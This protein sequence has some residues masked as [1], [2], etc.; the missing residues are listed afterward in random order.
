MTNRRQASQPQGNM[1]N[2]SVRILENRE[3]YS[4]SQGGSYLHYVDTLDV[5]NL[6]VSGNII[7]TGDLDRLPPRYVT[8]HIQVTTSDTPRYT[9]ATR[10]QHY[11]A[12]A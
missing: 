12:L 5:A 1:H 6:S 11:C 7:G 10:S 9:Q 4:V 8:L 2:T 3:R